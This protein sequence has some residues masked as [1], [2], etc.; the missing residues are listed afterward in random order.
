[1]NEKN[2]LTVLA[3][4]V[5][6]FAAAVDCSAA[7]FEHKGYE[8]E[9]YWKVRGKNLN[10]WGDI[11]KGQQCKQLNVYVHLRN[12]RYHSRASIETL[13]RREHFP[14]GR[15][16]FKGQS[17]IRDNSYKEGWFVDR[18]SVTCSNLNPIN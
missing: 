11:E 5:L 6:V 9:V 16:V 4:F 14:N 13:V 3:L 15:S 10:V 7:K 18:L 12:N 17:K 8:V 1:M 2:I